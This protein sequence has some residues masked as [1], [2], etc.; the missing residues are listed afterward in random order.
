M[1]TTILHWKIWNIDGPR[2]NFSLLLDI[3]QVVIPAGALVSP[4][5]W[6]HAKK[7]TLD[8]RNASFKIC[9]IWTKNYMLILQRSVMILNFFCLNSEFR[10]LVCTTSS[11][12]DFFYLFQNIIDNN[13]TPTSSFPINLYLNWMHHSDL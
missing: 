2:W 11:Y 13:A 1:Y 12:D 7:V 8:L 9:H 6:R 10:I 4:H 5:L 3:S